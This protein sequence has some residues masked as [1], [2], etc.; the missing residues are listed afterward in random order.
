MRTPPLKI[1]C[2]GVP[3]TGS[4][5]VFETMILALVTDVA[6]STTG[7][8]TTGAVIDVS[9]ITTGA[10]IDVAAVTTG[11]VIDVAAVTTGA[12]I[13]VAAVT[14]GSVTLVVATRTGAVTLV[15]ATMVGAFSV[16]TLSSSVYKDAARSVS[17]QPWLEATTWV[18]KSSG[19]QAVPHFAAC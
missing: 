10:V 13:D 14:T 18:P 12:V 8:V 5:S 6:A 15:V 4:V 9:A 1:N 2:P 16:R 3:V 19:A 17:K 11:A 7:A